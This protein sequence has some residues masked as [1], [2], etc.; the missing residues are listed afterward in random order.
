MGATLPVLV[1]ALLARDPNFGSVLGRLYGWNT[2]GAVAGAVAGEWFLIECFGIRGTA[3]RRRQLR[4]AAAAVV[5]LGLSRRLA[6]CGRA[7][8]G[9]RLRRQ[10]IGPRAPAHR[11]GGLYGAGALLLAFEVV[12]F[13]FMHLFVH[14]GSL[15]FALML[16]VV[17]AGIALGGFVGGY[18]LR[19]YPDAHR[20]TPLLA[21]AAGAVAVTLYATFSFAY[22]RRRPMNC[23]AILPSC[24]GC[25]SFWSFRSR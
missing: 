16:A 19:R 24:S 17:L 5:A 1:K 7:R 13:R 12:W 4:R 8:V 3:Y 23:L 2:L 20:Y 25:R 22:L 6:T 11:G 10:S 18:C 15:A 9:L 21:L 14:S